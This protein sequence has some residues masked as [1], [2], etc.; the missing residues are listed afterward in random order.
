MSA[1]YGEQQQNEI[2][3][4]KKRTFMLKLSDADVRRI[5][6]KAGGAG[7]TVSELLQ[8]FIGDLVCGT[9]S[10]GADERDDAAQ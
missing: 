7:M 1:V 3:T 5:Y 10:K 6:E 2:A 4:I 9:Y 8:N